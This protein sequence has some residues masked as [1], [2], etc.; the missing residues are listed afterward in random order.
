MGISDDNNNKNNSRLKDE[1]EGKYS[2]RIGKNVRGLRMLYK[3]PQ[4]TLTRPSQQLTRL[5]VGTCRQNTWRRTKRHVL[6]VM[7]WL[8]T[9][10]PHS[11]MC[12]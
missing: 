11:P 2:C 6:I 3:L 5:L 9:T 8:N 1:N 12:A 7:G 10:N 4:S